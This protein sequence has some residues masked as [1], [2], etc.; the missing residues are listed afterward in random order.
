MTG[1]ELLNKAESIVK[2][3]GF[4][5]EAYEIIYKMF[6]DSSITVIQK[7]SAKAELKK[8]LALSAILPD[9]IAMFGI[10]VSV[11]I[12]G[13]DVANTIFVAIMVLIFAILYGY[14]FRPAI[15]RGNYVLSIIEDI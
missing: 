13:Y 2:E 5:D 9:L 7:N 15:E 1:K 10:L 11:G 12:I 6:A 8:D 14:K 4:S 3:K